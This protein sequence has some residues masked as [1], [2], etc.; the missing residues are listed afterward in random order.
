[1]APRCRLCGDLLATGLQPLTG[2]AHVDAV[3]VLA[4]QGTAASED[5][6]LFEVYGL[7]VAVVPTHKPRI[8]TDHAPIVYYKCAHVPALRH[9]SSAIE[10]PLSVQMHLRDTLSSAWRHQI[11]HSTRVRAQDAVGRACHALE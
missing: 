9:P 4:A 3:P 2:R 7:T 1:M 5:E 11:H 6:E 8:R 10:G